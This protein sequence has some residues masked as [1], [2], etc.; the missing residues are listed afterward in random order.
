MSQRL[1]EGGWELRGRGVSREEELE[2]GLQLEERD[3]Q[4][5]R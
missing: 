3:G 5:L 2:G 1:T 4:E